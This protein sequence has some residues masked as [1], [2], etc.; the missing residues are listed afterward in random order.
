[1]PAAVSFELIEVGVR[2]GVAENAAHRDD[3]AFVV[4]SVGEDV[5]ED[6]RRSADSCVS[7]GEMK[8]GGGIE[9]VLGEGGEIGK[10]LAHGSMLQITDIGDGGPVGGI[11]VGVCQRAEGVD[12][13]GFAVEDV[14]HLGSEAGGAEAR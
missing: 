2:R 3:L 8:F 12:P 1:M 6:E 7:V 11:F 10:R 13:E 4:E 9:L 14:Q 5:M